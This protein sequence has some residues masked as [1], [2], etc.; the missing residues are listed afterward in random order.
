MA[1]RAFPDSYLG[2]RRQD[3]TCSL[4]AALR[5]GTDTQAKVDQIVSYAER[6]ALLGDLAHRP[7]AG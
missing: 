4:E 1:D 3:L 6:L 5:G 2:R 7:P